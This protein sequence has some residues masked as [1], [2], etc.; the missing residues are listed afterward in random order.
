MRI[1]QQTHCRLNALIFGLLKKNLIGYKICVDAYFD[2][3][4]I[5]YF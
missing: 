1:R 5:A 4:E 2:F 3:G